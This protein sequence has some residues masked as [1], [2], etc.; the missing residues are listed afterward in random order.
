MDFTMVV[1]GIRPAASPLNQN[2]RASLRSRRS[3]ATSSVMDEQTMDFTTAVG[4]IRQQASPVRRQSVGERSVDDNEDMS[5]EFTAVIGGI[6]PHEAGSDVQRPA[7]PKEGLSP[8]RTEVPT[9]PN[10][11]G[12][13][14]A[15]EDQ[16][17]KKL[18][19]P[20]FEK[21]LSGSAVKD[22][23]GS[24][25][26][27]ARISNRSAQ[28]S[29][30][31][32]S[33]SP[34]SVR[35]APSSPQKNASPPKN[36]AS[37]GTSNLAPSSSA[38]VRKTSASTQQSPASPRKSKRIAASQPTAQNVEQ[39]EQDSTASS[40]VPTNDMSASLP[41][42]QSHD[43]LPTSIREA[44][45]IVYPTLP[46]VEV[47]E[48]ASPIPQD[49]N[50]MTPVP[51]VDEPVTTPRPHH[52]YTISE[53]GSPLAAFAQ[54]PPE[55]D[56]ENLNPPSPS[57]EK[58]MR[59]SPVTKTTTPQQPVSRE[60]KTVINPQQTSFQQPTKPETASTTPPRTFSPVE[61]SRAFSDS[62]RLMSTP[63][64][65]TGTT[66]LKRLRGMTPMKSPEKKT[67]TPHKA[68]TPKT[69]T[70]RMPPRTSA[71]E[72]AGQQLAD[73]LFAATRTDQQI[74]KVKLNDF[75]EKAGIKF[76]ELAL[77]TKRRYTVAPG[78]VNGTEGDDGSNSIDLE[79]AV[80]A[81]ACTTPMLDMFQH[82]CRELKRYISEGKSFVKTLETEVYADTPPLISAY[83]NAT[84]QRKV[85]LDNHMRD[86]K[87]NARLCSKE[88][89]YDWRSKLLDGLEEGLKSIKAKL[90]DDAAILG[91]RENMLESL[92]PD[93]LAKHD[94]LHQEAVRLEEAAAS[95]SEE[96]QEE[97]DTVRQ[98][99]GNVNEQIE[100]KKRMLEAME[101]E[102]QEQDELVEAYT[103]GKGECL[104]Q[105]S[106]AERVK[107]SCRGWSIDEVSALKGRFFSNLVSGLLLTYNSFSDSARDSNWLG[108]HFSVWFHPDNDIPT[109]TL[110]F[111]RRRRLWCFVYQSQRANISHLHSQL[112]RPRKSKASAPHDGKTLLPP[113][114]SRTPTVPRAAHDVDQ[115]PTRSRLA[116]LGRGDGNQR[117]H[118]RTADRTPRGRGHPVGRASGH[119]HRRAAAES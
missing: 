49:Q 33:K 76:M 20:M 84:P 66:P 112:C 31:G 71:A 64:K 102:L 72:L 69:K 94:A 63:R 75:L 43:S 52:A 28:K 40:S 17:A 2:R 18:L 5:M 13:F 47:V 11:E 118:P 85:Q 59:S 62:I 48:V 100:E 56:M 97:L 16:S 89:W 55:I 57:L 50:Q 74:T 80:V 95:V 24:T 96:E 21:Q 90:D 51:T 101:K 1:G 81:G 58:Q 116:R 32:V 78:Q 114:S 37:R 30:V 22:S 88:I 83:V 117:Q 91:E 25:R 106:E 104:A 36:A 68:L 61:P 111:L 110:T 54:T 115:I 105:I 39:A 9:T 34:G 42:T 67:V 70:P 26:S 113:A 108:H 103:E 53:A 92:L 38:S 107:E 93:L 29:P 109:I 12:H 14:K 82:S 10:R 99:L 4:G 15:A 79:S 46:D 98:T 65:D 44:D 19:T 7:T 3:S 27:S 87:T 45:D 77:P 73:E 41:S 119:L 8:A 60:S 86:I 35:K 6:T 23:A